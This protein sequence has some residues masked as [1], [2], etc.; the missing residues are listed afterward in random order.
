LPEPEDVKEEIDP[1]VFGT[2]FHEVMEQLYKPFIGKN[3][4]KSA[5]SGIQKKPALI[6]NEIRR[7]ISIHYFKEKEPFVTALE[8]KHL[9]VFE[10]LKTYVNRVIEIDKNTAPFILIG[11]EEKYFQTVGL[12][13]NGK[14]LV[15]NVGGT[16]DRID[17][18]GETVRI[19]DYKTGQVKKFSF[20]AVDELFLHDEKSPKKEILQ[21]LIY[22]W[23]FNRQNSKIKVQPAIYA[24]R[25][26]FGKDFDPDIKWD[27]HDFDWQ[28]LEPDF[29]MNLRDLISEIYSADSVF[30]QTEHTEKC[31]FCAYRAI[32][33][34]F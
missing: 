28:Q 31:R 9:L 26:L 13:L 1:Q 32:C 14:Q 8:G 3:V 27:K 16:I 15:V 33:Q 24:L 21:A 7:Q 19:I 23:A 5:L 12:S 22:A 18:V 2:V 29:L 11:L 6:E 20:N 10:N 30:K 34:R 25:N 17:R 4:T